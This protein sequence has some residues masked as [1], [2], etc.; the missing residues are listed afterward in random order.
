MGDWGG[1]KKFSLFVAVHLSDQTQE[2]NECLLSHN[3][4]KPHAGE[5]TAPDVDLMGADR[6]AASS[7]VAEIRDDR[8]LKGAATMGLCGQLMSQS[9]CFP[10]VGP[11]TMSP[12][13]VSGEPLERF[14]FPLN[15]MFDQLSLH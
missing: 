8:L 6:S 14:S 11:R 10:A 7:V 5:W 2:M 9:A 3:V 4:A 15:R 13:S 1:S 12:A